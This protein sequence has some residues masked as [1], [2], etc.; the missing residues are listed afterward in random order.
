MISPKQDKMTYDHTDKST[1]KPFYFYSP[2]P[3]LT[4]PEY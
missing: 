2:D 4:L 1:Y 3:I